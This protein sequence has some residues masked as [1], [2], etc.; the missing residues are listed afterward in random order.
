MYLSPNEKNGF[1]AILKNVARY[2]P[3]NN[4]VISLKLRRTFKY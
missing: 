4:F 2:R 3:A 1:A